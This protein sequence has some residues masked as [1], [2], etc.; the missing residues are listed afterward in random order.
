M[1]SKY[2]QQFPVPENFPQLLNDLVKEIIR[3]QPAEI[4][5]FSAMYFKCMQEGKVLDYPKKGKNIPCDFKTSVPVVRNTVENDSSDKSKQQ[6]EKKPVEQKNKSIDKT[7][8]KLPSKKIEPE[9][10]TKN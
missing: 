6:F 1:A 8:E 7:E 10:N 4:I 2:I 9:K 5:E 3:N